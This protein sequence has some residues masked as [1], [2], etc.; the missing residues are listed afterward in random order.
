VRSIVVTG[1]TGF[2]GSHLVSY[3]S[4]CDYDVY[5]VI[6]PQSKRKS[7]LIEN[8]KIHVSEGSLLD[9]NDL[10]ISLPKEPDAFFHLGWAGVS[11]EQRNNFDLQMQNVSLAQGAV[12]LASALK[13]KKFIIPG[14]TLEYAYY[15][16]PINEN[17][18]PSPLNA[19]GEAKLAAQQ[20]CRQLCRELD[21]PFVYAVISGIYSEDRTDNNVI[22]YTIRTLL[23][24]EKPEL[25]K[26]EQLWD[27][28]HIDDVVYALRLIAEKGKP[29]AF[30]A[31]GHGDNQPLWKYILTIRDLIDPELPLGI[32]M[33]PYMN[34]KVPSSCVDLE[35]LIRDTGFVP[36]VSFEDGISRVIEAVKNKIAE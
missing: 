28:I 15:G 33:V 24:G 3:L 11:P 35:P 5:A 18:N 8:D 10:L 2:L 7:I 4:K 26:L 36:Q 32:G 29:G 6:T 16:K 14:S 9:F 27:Y 23:K 31:V 21:I 25:T 13:A 30:Y 22:Y 34:G 1:A 20:A 19:Y 12:R 17:A